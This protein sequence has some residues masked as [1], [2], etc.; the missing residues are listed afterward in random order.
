MMLAQD[1]GWMTVVSFKAPPILGGAAPILELNVC[2]F[3]KQAGKMKALSN[4][5]SKT[6]KAVT[7]EEV[8]QSEAAVG[9]PAP[10]AAPC[11]SSHV[12]IMFQALTVL[13]LATQE[14]LPLRGV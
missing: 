4:P 2:L 9:G 3:S 11:W 13:T 6:E 14:I 5:R 7:E 8:S 1:D 12:G 10:S